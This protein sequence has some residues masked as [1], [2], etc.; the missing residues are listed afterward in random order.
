MFL[1]QRN[2]L[3]TRVVL[4]EHYPDVPKQ[5]SLSR[6]CSKNTSCRPPQAPGT[7]VGGP[8]GEPGRSA[9]ARV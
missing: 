5:D 6:T 1:E 9:T 7:F 4:V 3:R 8:M 2:V